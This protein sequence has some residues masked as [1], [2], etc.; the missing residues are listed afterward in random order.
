MVCLANGLGAELE[1]IL[2]PD[3]VEEIYL[4]D[5]RYRA[6]RAREDAAKKAGNRRYLS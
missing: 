3:L 5:A 2:P 6:A 1:R 4:K